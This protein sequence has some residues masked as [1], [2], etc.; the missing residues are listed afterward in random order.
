MYKTLTNLSRPTS[1]IVIW[2]IVFLLFSIILHTGAIRSN[3]ANQETAFLEE[4]SGIYSIPQAGYAFSRGSSIFSFYTYGAIKNSL[5]TTG[6]SIFDFLLFVGILILTFTFTKRLTKD[7]EAGLIAVILISVLPTL[8][9]ITSFSSNALLALFFTFC[10]ANF[11]LL[12]AGKSTTKGWLYSI[13]FAVFGVLASTNDFYFF[14]IMASALI[15][16]AIL[17]PLRSLV[18]VISALIFLILLLYIDSRLASSITS[19]VSRNV[20][21]G[22]VIHNFVNLLKYNMLP[23]MLFGLTMNMRYRYGISNKVYYSLIAFVIIPCLLS[24]FTTDAT[25]LIRVT[26]YTAIPAVPYAASFA[27]DSARNYD[28]NFF[29]A[30]FIILVMALICAGMFFI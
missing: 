21:S 3:H 12:A 26:S 22:N 18:A 14:I 30:I 4:A 23:L 7:R 15:L 20:A 8:F 6:I 25:M 27:K 10:A 2:S 29:G 28:G 16:L 11:F 1:R 13:L 24:L 9:Y 5:G 19:F 17:K